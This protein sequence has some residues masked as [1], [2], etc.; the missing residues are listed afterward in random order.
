MEV[1]YRTH[2]G[3]FATRSHTLPTTFGAIMPDENLNGE[4]DRGV[5]LAIGSKQQWNGLLLDFKASFT[6]ARKK[7]EY[8]E[9]LEAGNQYAYWEN[10]SNGASKNPYRWDNIT[11][12]YEALGQFQSFEEILQSPIQDGE[13]NS[14]LLPGDIRYKDLNGDGLINSLDLTPIGRSD[15]PEIFFGFNLS[16]EWKNFDF[17]LFFQGASHYT[18]TLN[19]KDAFVQGGI[20]N[21]YKMYKDRWHRADVNDPYSEWIP[22]R[23][24]PLR[25]EGFTGNQPTSTFWSKNATYLRLKTI[26]LGYTLPL[27]LTEK[28]GIQKFRIYINAYNLLT[29]T[30]KWLK[31]V[32]PEGESGY[33]LYYPQMKTV[34]F[35]INVEF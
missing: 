2:T 35:G 11:W 22:G 21:A 3:M 10:R 15:R 6:Y 25:V 27:E 8:Q 23:F 32:D 18:Y 12:G 33:G 34:N 17:T 30:S 29:F 20:G 4:T 16:A 5:E 28:A 24:P 31:Y 26:D 1:F 19:Y 7:R 9:L 13:G 14:T